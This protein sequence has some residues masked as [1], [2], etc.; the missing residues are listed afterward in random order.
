MNNL[1]WVDNKIMKLYDRFTDAETGEL[2]DWKDEDGNVIAPVED[3]FTQLEA[4]DMERKDVIENLLLGYKNDTAEAEAIKLEISRLTARRKYCEN[5][6]ERFKVAA[7]DALDGESFTS[8][9]VAVRWTTSRKAASDD[10]STAPD[11]YMRVKVEMKPDKNAIK[12]AIKSGV[13]V[14][15]WWIAESKSMSVK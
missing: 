7:A 3:F 12:A 8:G 5:R 2:C 10:E 15:G 11:E 14:P 4:L 6:A 13:D 9:K 1:Y